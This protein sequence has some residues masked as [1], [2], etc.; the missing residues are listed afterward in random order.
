MPQPYPRK[1]ISVAC[2]YCRHRKR[3]CDGVKPQYQLETLL[4]EKS[5]QPAQTRN[6]NE[7]ENQSEQPNCEVR[8]DEGTEDGEFDVGVEDL[9]YVE[10]QNVSNNVDDRFRQINETDQA[11]FLYSQNLNSHS[12]AITPDST[13]WHATS[14]ASENLF[15]NAVEININASGDNSEIPEA[16]DQPFS[17]PDGHLT[18]TGSLFLLEPIQR[19]IGEYPGNFF[20]HIESIRVPPFEKHPK[21][22]KE[23]LQNLNLETKTVD[24]LF[25]TFFTEVHI[26]FPILNPETFHKFFYDTMRQGPCE[27]LKMALCLIVL[28]LGKLAL[29]IQKHGS[30]HENESENGLEYFTPAHQVLLSSS[31]ACFD[32]DTTIPTGLLLSSIYLSYMS[33]PL[34]SWHMAYTASVKLQLIISK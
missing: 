1:R 3:R 20:Y 18:T 5:Q 32:L 12:A 30:I 24:L 33:Y 14:P 9:S 11:L 19:L 25:S 28:A 4:R 21:P 16:D 31:W 2:H 17:I 15:S 6:A 23:T 34:P 10:H 8:Y 13:L 29:S 22:P 27:S 26:H 7:K